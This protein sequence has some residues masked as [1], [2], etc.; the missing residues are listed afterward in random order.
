MFDEGFMPLIL[1]E[2]S[3]RMGPN[4]RSGLNKRFEFAIPLISL[5][6]RAECNRARSPRNLDLGFIVLKALRTRKVPSI[7]TH[8]RALGE[9][10]PPYQIRGAPRRLRHSFRKHLDEWKA[11]AEFEEVRGFRHEVALGIG[12]AHGQFTG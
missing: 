5:A 7:P 12:K 10:R 8:S 3:F 4:H 2:P 11:W 1:A 6:L 9:C